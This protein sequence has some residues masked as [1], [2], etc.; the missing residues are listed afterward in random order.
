MRTQCCN[1]PMGSV[2]C[3][4]CPLTVPVYRQIHMNFF[5]V[6][7]LVPETAIRR[8]EDSEEVKHAFKRYHSG[9]LTNYSLIKAILTV[10]EKFRINK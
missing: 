7:S 4:D 5:D 3:N 9:D 1:P 10:A 2:Q 6:S 8:I